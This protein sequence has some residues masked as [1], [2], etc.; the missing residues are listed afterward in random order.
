MA[1]GEKGVALLTAMMLLFL[2]TGFSLFVFQNAMLEKQIAAYSRKEAVSLALAESG[3][4][5]VVAWFASPDFSPQPAFFKKRFCKK[6]ESTPDFSKTF[7]WM[8]DRLVPFSDGE[9][10]RI[11][12]YIYA[13]SSPSSKGRCRVKAVANLGRAVEVDLARP[14]MPPTPVPIYGAPAD[15]LF[16]R[17]VHWEPIPSGNETDPVPADL[18]RLQYFVKRFGR[19]LVLSP[20][21]LL[22]ENGRT[23]GRF[24]QVFGSSEERSLVFIDIGKSGPLRIEP[25]SYK[26]YFYV[27]GDVD[28][29]GSGPSRS[30]LAMAPPPPDLPRREILNDI[31][32]EGFLYTPGRITVAGPF[33]VYGAIYAGSGLAGPGPLTV[34]Y[35]DQFQSGQYEGVVPL[36]RMPGT[37]RTM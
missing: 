26:G 9:I 11:D 22:E 36:I 18:N 21:G 27:S 37:W 3:I 14:P 17:M 24:D 34:W 7:S 6:S 23:L 1:S 2:I 20:S 19:Y 8:E 15:A 33:Q 4:D 28:I 29:D 13:S 30:V 35:N 31:H 10:S 32:L 5:Q 25:G 16:Q 12:L